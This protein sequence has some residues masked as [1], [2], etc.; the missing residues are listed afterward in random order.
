MSLSRICPCLGLVCLGLVLSRICPCLGYVRVQDMS[1]LGLVVSR[2][3]LS[4]ICPVQVWSCLGFVL[5]PQVVAASPYQIINDSNY[6]M[7]Y[8]LKLKQKNPRRSKCL[9]LNHVSCFLEK[10]DLKSRQLGT[11]SNRSMRSRGSG[12]IWKNVFWTYAL[13]HGL[14][15]YLYFLP[16]GLVAKFSQ[17]YL[18]RN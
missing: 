2:F 9:K 16:F 12:K 7:K 6:I 10:S 15:A 4:R 11:Y 18:T 1:C 13:S 17:R 8:H 14:W 3:G 5:A